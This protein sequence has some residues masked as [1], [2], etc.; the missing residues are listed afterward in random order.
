MRNLRRKL[1]LTLL[2]VLIV[3]AVVSVGL[4]G[5]MSVFYWGL[6]AGE[7]GASMTQAINYCREILEGIRVRNLAFAGAN[8]I[9]TDSN[10]LGTHQLAAAPLNTFGF[11]TNTKY[12]REIKINRKS[13]SGYE[14]RI[15]V[16]NVSVVWD[17]KNGKTKRVE[18][19]GYASVQ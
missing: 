18:M 4:I 11:P 3:L 15:A 8:T 6:S 9:T 1:G 10:L 19:E 12:R 17:T 14:A 7:Q 2:E 16:I 5:T 13:S